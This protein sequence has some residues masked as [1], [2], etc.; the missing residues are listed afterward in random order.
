MS[1]LRLIELV[2]TRLAMISAG[3]KESEEA[4]K[5]IGHLFG[6]TGPFDPVAAFVLGAVVFVVGQAHRHGIG[7]D[8]VL[9]LL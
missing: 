8:G 3:L 7:V 4:Q 6:G 9:D 2:R 1:V 5:R